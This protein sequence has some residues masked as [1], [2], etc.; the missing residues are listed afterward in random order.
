MQSSADS[1]L[2]AQG[3]RGAQQQ[4]DQPSA[5]SE[6]SAAADDVG[7]G[8]AP[9]SVSTLDTAPSLDAEPPTAGARHLLVACRMLALL[10][11]KATAFVMSV[12]R[13]VLMCIAWCV[14]AAWFVSA[15]NASQHAA[16]STRTA[17]LCWQARPGLIVLVFAPPAEWHSARQLSTQL[18]A[19]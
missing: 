15:T 1:G 17:T 3:Q 9:D 6:L 16:Q 19:R 14:W 12:I 10:S 13:S 7:P 4:L 18:K 8:P 11:L 2:C 5:A